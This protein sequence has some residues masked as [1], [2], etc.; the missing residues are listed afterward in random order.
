[1]RTKVM[2]L[3]IIL[4]MFAVASSQSLY[5][6]TY[7]VSPRDTEVDAEDIFDRAYNGL[8]NVG[9]ETQMY[10][11]ARIDEGVLTA[12]V[13][14]I[15]D[16]PDGSTAD[17][18]TS[19]N[20]DESTQVVT[21]TPSHVGTYVVE[22]MD[23]E[24]S[25]SLSIN[26]GTYMGMEAGMCGM[27]HSEKADAWAETGHSDMLTRALDGT[28]SSHYAGYCVGCHTVGYDP[29]ANNGGF[30]DWGFVYPDSTDLV[31]NYGSED[32][33]LFEG[34][35]DLAVGFYPDA[36][37]RANIQCES[38]H[39]PG[40][41]H[42]GNTSDSKMVAGLE[43]DNCAWCHDSGTHHA[44]PEQWDYSGHATPP[45]RDSWS[46]SC[47]RCH[48]PEGFIEYVEGNEVNSHETSPFSCAMCHDPHA[49]DNPHQMRT[50]EST[51]LSNGFEVE[52]G[53]YGRLCMNC[54]M[55]RRDADTYTDGPHG[56]YGPHYGVQADML[57][58]TNAI[59][60]GMNIPTSPHLSG[61]ENSCVDCHMAG[62]LTD[63]DGN[64]MLMGGHSWNMAYDE[65]DNLV[66]CEGCHGDIGGS[67]DAKVFFANG[68]GDH[69]GDGDTEGLQH[70]VEGLMETLAAM[71]PAV[72]GFD[73]Y[74]PHDD[75]DDTWTV[76][77]LKAAYNY[78][79]V[80]YDHSHGIHNPAFTVGLLQVSIQAL[81]NGA[82]DGQIVAVD[83]IPN[84]QGGQVKV[85]WD[86][87]ASDG[88]GYDPIDSYSLKRY[89][90]YDD[91]WTFVGNMPA[92]GSGRYSLVVPTLFDST[93]VDPALT[94]FIVLAL[95]EGGDVFTSDPAD[96]YSLDNL[97]PM[98]P[99]GIMA[100]SDESLVE[101]VWD[102]ALDADFQYFTIYRNG[103]IVGYSTESY[104]VDET[105]TSGG[106]YAYTITATDVNENESDDSTPGSVFAGFSGDI[107][108]D[109][110]IDVLDVVFL[111]GI[112][113]DNVEYNDFNLWAADR[114]GDGGIDV[115]DVVMIID[116]ILGDT[117]TK[118]D[119]ISNANLSYGNGI[120]NV[121]SDGTVAGVQ[122]SVKGEFDILST[123]LPA[124]WEIH[125]NNNT[126]LAFTT[127]GSSLTEDMKIYYDGI[128]VVK[129]GT[130]ADWFGGG[131]EAELLFV[132]DVYSLKP[133]YPNP[134]NPVT[135]ISFDIPFESM[136][137]ITI[138]DALG[139]QVAVLVNDM[140]TAGV[141]QITWNAEAH[142]SGLYIVKMQAGDF[143]KTQKILLIK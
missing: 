38:C 36:M 111:V 14:T 57:A 102:E 52:G 42:F 78:D 2:S 98:V 18:G 127:N 124:G 54:H 81:L 141:K 12:P 140:Q 3:F 106:E 68:I 45:S 60:F 92:D 34:V 63:D 128:V 15:T 5:V 11:Q 41:A 129:S 110:E 1:M 101:I 29:D 113:L 40:N 116:D 20:M 89:D 114:N 73:A 21:F 27:C 49:L 66:A 80:Y 13:W 53:G 31:D 130:V 133:A 109:F 44:F 79:Y 76:T 117:L 33:H 37:A 47:A 55:S 86:A 69:D 83:D 84:D 74:D 50:V 138:Y 26:S 87:F 105:I 115:L 91:T 112:I 85:I 32:G 25:Y 70:E 94:S 22:F 71:L 23:G 137:Q 96:G 56:H 142:S 125:N 143:T 28:L 122:I 17:F 51:I 8:L 104:F 62:D 90:G 120:I 39:G 67:F 107:N 48:T 16:A 93:S 9:V 100:L 136:V 10:F 121:S 82:L 7:G 61:V 95:S 64:I 119:F 77:E 126:I 58:A 135:N 99:D 43:T 35:F 103:E 6:G 65:V 30:D 19:F 108:G 118:G 139:R 75:V 46:G 97:A 134:F 88:I 4:T 24:L 132:P 72:E 59:T 123:N 131:S